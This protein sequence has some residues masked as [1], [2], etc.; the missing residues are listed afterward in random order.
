MTGCSIA[1][2]R[3]RGRAYAHH[4]RKENAMLDGTTT[5]VVAVAT[6]FA[7]V[8]TKTVDLIRNVCSDLELPKWLWNVSA[9]GLGIGMALAWQINI[10]DNYSDKSSIVQ[11]VFGR[12][13]TGMSI[14]GVSSG[15]HELFDVLSSSAKR[16]KYG[17]QAAAVARGELPEHVA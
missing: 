9:L 4:V 8:V 14:G 12:V 11:G 6:V 17:D 15:Y 5:E 7:M 10:L 3:R 1:V 16:A 2:S 13:L